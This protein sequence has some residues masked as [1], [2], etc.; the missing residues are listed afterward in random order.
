[1]WHEYELHLSYYFTVFFRFVS[2]LEDMFSSM[3]F[4]QFLSISLRICLI[5][6]HITM[7][8]IFIFSPD[9]SVTYSI[10]ETQLFIVQFIRTCFMFHDLGTFVVFRL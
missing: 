6:F 7:V 9:I 10:S 4:F 1:M 3:M 8:N 5:I 2:D